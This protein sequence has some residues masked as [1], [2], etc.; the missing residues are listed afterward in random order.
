MAAITDDANPIQLKLLTIGDSGNRYKYVL[1]QWILPGAYT[2][3]ILLLF[4][5]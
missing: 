4:Q 3:H 2:F 1:L 5:E